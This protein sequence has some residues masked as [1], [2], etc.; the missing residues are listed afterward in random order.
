MKPAREYFYDLILLAFGKW[1][2][3]WVA[4]RLYAF[5]YG[6]DAVLEL[7]RQM[8]QEIELR[9]WRELRKQDR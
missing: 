2:C 5:F 7:H 8:E 4:I 1:L 6:M 3:F 9:K